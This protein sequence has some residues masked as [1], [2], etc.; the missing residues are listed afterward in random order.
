MQVSMDTWTEQLKEVL[1]WEWLNQNL[2]ECLQAIEQG[3]REYSLDEE[4]V[5]A[6]S[7]ILNLTEQRK[8]QT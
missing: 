3:Q 5:E 7:V 4:D 8:M 2:E 1:S 6:Q